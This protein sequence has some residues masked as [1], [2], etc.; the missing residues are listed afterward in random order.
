MPPARASPRVGWGLSPVR[1]SSAGAVG[2]YVIDFKRQL[3]R[4]LNS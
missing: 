3:Y 1:V 2:K 4:E